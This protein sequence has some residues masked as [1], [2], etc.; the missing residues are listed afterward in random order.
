MDFSGKVVVI[1]GGNRG[2]GFTTAQLYE[3][4]GAIVVI[5][6]LTTGELGKITKRENCDTIYETVLDVSDEENAKNV[7]DMTVQRFGKID[8]LINNAGVTKGAIPFEEVDM[9]EW[10]GMFAINTFGIV[11]CVKAA[12][13]YMK[14]QKS[15]K[16][17]ISSSLAAETGGIRTIAPYSASK[18]ANI[19]MMVTLAKTLGPF[20]ITVNGVAPGVIDTEMTKTLDPTDLNTIPLRKIGT[21]EDVG[22]AI[23]FLTSKKADYLTGVMMDVNGGMYFR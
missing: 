20:N 22:N 14:K 5:G 9:D 19:C 1:T 17:I 11:H 18:A 15:G 12:I 16:I 4:N 10:K 3:K 21:A 7:I 23:L 6:D 8:I 2:I 13:P